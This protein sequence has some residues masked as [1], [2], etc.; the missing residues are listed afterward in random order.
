MRHLTWIPRALATYRSELLFL[1]VTFRHLLFTCQLPMEI[2]LTHGRDEKRE[3][4]SDR[5]EDGRG[6]VRIGKPAKFIQTLEHIP[7]QAG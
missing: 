3:A 7:C 4:D 1:L 2:P 6:H 5:H